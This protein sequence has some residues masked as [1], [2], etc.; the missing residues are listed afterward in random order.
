M[1]G[2]IPSYKVLAGFP[3]GIADDENNLRGGVRVLQ[4]HR[5][6]FPFY[7]RAEVDVARK[8]SVIVEGV[9]EIGAAC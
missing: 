5:D 7:K 4:R 2:G 8:V 1:A 3:R 6:T 9:V